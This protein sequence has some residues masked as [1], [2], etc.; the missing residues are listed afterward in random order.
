[1]S[2]DTLVGSSIL[3]LTFCNKGVEGRTDDLVAEEVTKEKGGGR[4]WVLY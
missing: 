3:G 4:E 2:P 1:M